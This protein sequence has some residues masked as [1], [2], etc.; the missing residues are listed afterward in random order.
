MP[1]RLAGHTLA[2]RCYGTF[3]S[4]GAARFWVDLEA[5][6]TGVA[7][8]ATEIAVRCRGWLHGSIEGRY[9]LSA[10]FSHP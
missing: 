9:V 1:F 7:P 6:G 4:G 10:T 8:L 3:S 2:V 5:R